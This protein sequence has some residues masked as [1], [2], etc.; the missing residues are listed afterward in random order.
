[1]SKV[2]L[3]ESAKEQLRRLARELVR[4]PAE[5]AVR[6]AAYG[7]AEALVRATV[8]R[9]LPPADMAVLKRYDACRVDD[10]VRV[11]LLVGGMTVFRF[12][13]GTGPLSIN[14]RT[15]LADAATTDVVTAHALAQSA[16]RDALDKK[17]SDYY[18][19]INGARNLEDVTEVWPEAEAVRSSLGARAMTILS[20]DALER[21]RRDVSERQAA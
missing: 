15:F 7:V 1:M 16:Y 20:S 19:L 17:L 13:K 2:R 4:V 6:D 21:I 12:T 3:N 10:C 9:A 18:A 8:E 11:T 14:C 5:E